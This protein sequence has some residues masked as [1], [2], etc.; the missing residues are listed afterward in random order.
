VILPAW[1]DCYDFA[2]RAEFLG[3]GRWGSRKAAPQWAATELGSV[4][5]DVML[6]K[7]AGET[8]A[9]AAALAESIQRKGAGRQLAARYILEELMS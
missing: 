2:H 9:K 4:L 8:K 1:G 6:G 5:F 7:Q 3:V